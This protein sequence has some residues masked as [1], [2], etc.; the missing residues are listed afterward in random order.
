MYGRSDMITR[1]VEE[2]GYAPLSR[3]RTTQCI[4][5][6]S[7]RVGPSGFLHG[8]DIVAWAGAH[9]ITVTAGKRRSFLVRLFLGAKD[10]DRVVIDAIREA[11]C[12]DDEMKHSRPVF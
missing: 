6:G 1:G 3:R 5:G 4:N 12:A 2:G 11:H 10:G 9:P 7:L 8:D